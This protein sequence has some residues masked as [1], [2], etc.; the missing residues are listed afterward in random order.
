LWAACVMYT[1]MTSFWIST[2]MCGIMEP[3][4]DVHRKMFSVHRH[5]V[6]MEVLN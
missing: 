4:K 6:S 5:P 2:A 3:R 1:S